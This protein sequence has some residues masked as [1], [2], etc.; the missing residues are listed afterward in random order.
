MRNAA[1]PFLKF[2]IS[3]GNGSVAVYID[4]RCTLAG[5]RFKGDALTKHLF[6]GSPARGLFPGKMGRELSGINELQL[7]SRRMA[8]RTFITTSVRSSKSGALCVNQSTLSR[9]L[10]ANSAA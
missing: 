7:A 10:S 1:Q 9:I 2:P 4:G 6:P 8:H 5:N 3:I